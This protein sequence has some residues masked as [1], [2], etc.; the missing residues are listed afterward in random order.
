M[1]FIH[2]VFGVFAIMTSHSKSEVRTADREIESFEM[3]S[4]GK[5]AGTQKDD[6][7]MRVLGRKQVLNV[8]N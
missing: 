3:D 5:W 6:E 4:R 8:G 2:H 1:T 7:D